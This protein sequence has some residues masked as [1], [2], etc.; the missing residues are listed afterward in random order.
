MLMILSVLVLKRS[1]RRNYYSVS[2]NSLGIAPHSAINPRQRSQG[3]RRGF[4]IFEIAG[5][6]NAW[7][8]QIPISFLTSPKHF[9]AKSKSSFVCPADTWVRIRALPWGTTG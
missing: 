8:A 5:E 3:R 4:S 2:F 7:S 1:L 9:T 6:A